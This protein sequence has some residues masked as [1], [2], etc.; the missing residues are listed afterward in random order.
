MELSQR[1][2]K[3]T[4]LD[5]ESCNCLASANTTQTSRLASFF[6]P[7]SVHVPGRRRSYTTSSPPSHLAIRPLLPLLHLSVSIPLAD[8]LPA[9]RRLHPPS[10]FL[11]WASLPTFAAIRRGAVKLFA[12]RGRVLASLPGPSSE[13]PVRSP[14]P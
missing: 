4:D 10:F 14:P 6:L 1:K 2:R 3:G 7:S 12:L 11:R 5:Y 13:E 8:Q 9:P